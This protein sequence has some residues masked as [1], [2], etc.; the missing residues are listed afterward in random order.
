MPGCRVVANLLEEFDRK[1]AAQA[2]TNL[3]PLY[4]PGKSG[5]DSKRN[6]S[7][8][9]TVNPTISMLTAPE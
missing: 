4:E 7:G 1:E 3:R 8:P 6:Y 9:Q 2:G 5:I